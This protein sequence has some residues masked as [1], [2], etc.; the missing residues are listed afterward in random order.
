MKLRAFKL[1]MLAFCILPRLVAAQT[2]T[3]ITGNGTIGYTGDNG[4]ASAATLY[5]PYGVALSRNG[6]VLVLDSWN[7]CLRQISASGEITTI[8][9]TGTAGLSGDNGPATAAMLNYPMGIAVDD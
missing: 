4:P 7:S 2:I 1:L 3:T 6:N 5:Q 8:A 9:G